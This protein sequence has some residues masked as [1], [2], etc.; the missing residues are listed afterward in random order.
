VVVEDGTVYVVP[1]E[2]PPNLPPA[3]AR[4][5]VRSIAVVGASLAGL[6][7]ARALRGQGF[8]GR[9]TLIGTE[10]HRSWRLRGPAPSGS[11]TH[12]AS[13][14]SRTACRHAGTDGRS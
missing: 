14:S 7:A 8:D 11:V 4:D 6:S 5:G 12:A 3:S 9:L 13:A 10:S 1:S 2:E